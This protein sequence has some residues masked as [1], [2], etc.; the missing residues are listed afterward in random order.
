MQQLLPKFDTLTPS[1]KG[2]IKE[3]CKEL[4]LNV[5]F[6]TKCPD[7][8]RDGLI[9]LKKYFGIVTN[10]STNT[11]SGKWAYQKER[12]TYWLGHIR[13]DANTPDEI[14][15]DFRKVAGNMFEE[16]Y[17]SIKKEKDD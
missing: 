14:I 3:A 13:L 9:L 8:Y 10:F 12:P 1:D 4:G 15:E 17:K 6:K 5:T 2:F 7:C 11:P 16:F